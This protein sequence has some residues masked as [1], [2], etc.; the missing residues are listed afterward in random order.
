MKKKWLLPVVISLLTIPF[1]AA[2]VTD[3]VKSIWGKFLY[4]GGLGFLGLGPDAAVIAFTRILIWL[5]MF[6]VFFGVLTGLGAGGGAGGIAPMKF[7]TRGQAGI[8]A[9]AVATIAAVFLPANILAATG[10]GWATAVALLLIGGPIVG[11]GYL[12]ITYPQG[13]DTKA[14]VAVK[15]VICLLLFWI[16]TAMKYHVGRIV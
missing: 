1:V 4:I 13:G 6:S 7:F 3:T 2:A 9:A 8:V 11:L 10:A 5:L 14:T 16:L 12:L 15:I